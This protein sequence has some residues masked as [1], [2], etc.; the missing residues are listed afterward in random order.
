MEN[1]L[2][3]FKNLVE[4]KQTN[5]TDLGEILETCRNNKQKDPFSFIDRLSSVKFWLT[6]TKVPA[7][8]CSLTPT[9][10]RIFELD[11]ED[12]EYFKNKYLPKLDEEY[13]ENLKELNSKYNK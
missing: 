12:L 11:S 7:G 8:G 1:K 6:Y 13:E 9:P 4:E 5:D 3:E 2:L 10:T